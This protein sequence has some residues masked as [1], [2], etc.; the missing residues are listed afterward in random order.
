[1]SSGQSFSSI[2]TMGAAAEWDA[3][4]ALAQL[5]ASVKISVSK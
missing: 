5:S 2:K 4:A 3:A 1:V